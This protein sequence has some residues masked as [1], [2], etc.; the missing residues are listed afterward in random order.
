M[1]NH[2]KPIFFEDGPPNLPSGD[3]LQ[4]HH[5]HLDPELVLGL[6]EAPGE[7]RELDATQ[8]PSTV[9]H[10]NACRRSGRLRRSALLLSENFHDLRLR[11]LHEIGHHPRIYSQ[12]AFFPFVPHQVILVRDLGDV[13]R[14]ANL[15]AVE[16]GAP[17]VVF[18]LEGG[19]L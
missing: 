2:T 19:L 5:V 9:K 17:R 8:I 15:R 10:F 16:P 6:L 11:D 3:L 12:A 1:G 13:D 4:G 18:D 14:G 7:Q